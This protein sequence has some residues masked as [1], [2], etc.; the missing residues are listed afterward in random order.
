MTRNIFFSSD[1]HFNHAR[2]IQ[3][4]G[5]PFESAQEMNETLIDNHNAVVKPGDLT[6]FLGD[7][8]FNRTPEEVE[9]ILSRLNGNKILIEGNHD[10]E[11]IRYVKGWTATYFRV[12][13]WKPTNK[14]RPWTLAH[15]PHLSWN[16]SHRG[17]FHL[18]GHTHGKLHFDPT[19][20]R[21]DVGV[22]THDFKPWHYDEV[23]SKLNAVPLHEYH[24]DSE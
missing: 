7:F 14:S 23:V 12:F 19:V 24:N 18:H 17:A 21:L 11:W 8:A 20:R 5:R 16:Q 3:Y 6:F 4:C 13:E 1:P 9:A 2:I 10:R 22:D 15:F